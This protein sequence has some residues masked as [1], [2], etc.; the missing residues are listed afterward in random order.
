MLDFRLAK[1]LTVQNF[2]VLLNLGLKVSY[3]KK[4]TSMCPK[5]QNL[6]SGTGTIKNSLH[7]ICCSTQIE[8]PVLLF[9]M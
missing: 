6:V 3:L 5:L 7:E 4:G 2:A 1:H 9:L 8:D